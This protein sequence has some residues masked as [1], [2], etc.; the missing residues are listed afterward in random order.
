MSFGRGNLTFPLGSKKK[1]T[2]FFLVEL[3]S[4]TGANVDLFVYYKS[5][6]S[7]VSKLDLL[8]GYE[9]NTKNVRAKNLKV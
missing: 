3:D 8:V 4:Q 9:Y 6:Q 2:I 1:A 5:Y 7:N